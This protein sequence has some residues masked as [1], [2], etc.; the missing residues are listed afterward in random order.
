MSDKFFPVSFAQ[1][2]LLF[3][4]QLDP[5]ASAYNLTR[6]IRMVGPLD[7][8]ALSKTLN[9]I[10]QR[11]ASLRTKF[12]LEAEKAYQIVSD[13]V[14][15]QLPII[16]ISHLPNAVREPEAQRLAREEGHKI[17]NLTSGP[18]FRAILVRL[19]PAAH[20]LVLVMHHIITDGWS[21][22]ILFDEIGQ[23]YAE[24]TYARPARLPPL[25]IQYSDFA[26]WQ[27]EHLTAKTLH[28]HVTYWTHKL[29]GHHG[30]LELPTDRPRPAVQSH[31]GAIKIF[32][33]GEQLTT[34]LTQLANTH[35]A[36]L[37]MVLLSAF[38][39]LLW[40]YTGSDDILIGTPIAG[41]ND[42]QLE[43]LIGLFVNILVI[44]GDLSGNPSFRE[45][46][47]RTRETNSRSVR[48][49]R[50]SI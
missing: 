28:R 29:R 12:V 43:K 2:R 7:P 20:V 10:V 44:S 18:L 26:R 32:K 24:L 16:D 14:E 23:I 37:F 49:P 36:T 30:F 22:S 35:G 13:G 46:L 42:P 33:I 11:H 39:T 4:D 31:E 47:C 45:L 3:L 5:G 48:A 8:G 6:A 50:S 41:R 15:L 25:V 19:G 9:E 1:Q 34:A 17:F 38:Q 27:R 40:R 21:M